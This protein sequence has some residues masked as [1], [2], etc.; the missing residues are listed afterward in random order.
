[1]AGDLLAVTG[2]EHQHLRVARVATGEALEV[3]DG[4]GR[5]WSAEV[6]GVGRGETR[7]RLGPSRL[8]P[9][10]KGEIVLAAALIRNARFE[11]MIEKAVELGV[12]RIVPF[13]A[14]RSNERARGRQARWERMAV[15]AAKQSSQY[16]VP[17]IEPVRTLDHVL[18][19]PAASRI[20]LDEGG[21]GRMADALEG[22]PAMCLVGPEG[23]WSSGELER[24]GAAGWRP[25]HFRGRTLRAETAAVLAV[26]LMAVGLEVI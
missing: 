16:R 9:P 7:C 4:S 24:I 23:G 14:E 5:V 12:S 8:A 22:F 15:E 26:G 10:P 6:V 21:G 19:T 13:E 20:V 18:P 25:V 3:F 1:M 11:W 2:D 17:V